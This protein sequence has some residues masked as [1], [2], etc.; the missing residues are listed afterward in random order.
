MTTFLDLSALQLEIIDELRLAES[1]RPEE[2]MREPIEDWRFDPVEVPRYVA[3]LRGLLGAA[4]ASAH[5]DGPALD[6]IRR[7][8]TIGR[9][10]R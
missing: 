1:S 6:E 4:T 3:V 9:C 10:G 5:A 2:A 7:S 8:S